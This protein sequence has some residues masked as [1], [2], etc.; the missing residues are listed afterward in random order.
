MNDLTYA[1][2]QLLRAPGV[3]AASILTLA[4]GIGATTALFTI[5]NSILIRPLPYP[6]PDRLARV[7]SSYPDTRNDHGTVSMPDL[8][9][10]ARRSRTFDHMGLFSSL[11]SRLVLQ[12]EGSATELRTVHVSAGFFPVLGV[13]PALGRVLTAA[14][15]SEDPF[16][17]VVSHGFWQ[18]VLG[19]DST[20]IGRT[21]R[22]S[23]RPFTVVGVMP[24]GFGFPDAD[25]DVWALLAI[26]RPQEIPMQL[27]GV[28]FLNAIGRLAGGVTVEQAETDLSAVARGLAEE[29]PESNARLTAAHVVPLREEIVGPVRAGLLVLLGA[30]GLVLLIAC[31]N[32][33]NLRL[34][35]GTARGREFAIRTAT[36]AGRGRL[37]RLLLAESLVIAIVGGAAGWLTAVWAVEALAAR[38]AGVLPRLA[39]VGPNLT[40]LGFAVGVSLL[41]VLLSGMAPALI[42]TQGD[43]AARLKE[44]AGGGGRRSR[45]WGLVA[46]EVAVAFVLLVGAGLLVR[47]VWAL[48]RVDLGFEA[49]S[50]LAVTLT[51]PSAR[52]PERA[53]FLAMHA[54]LLQ[55]FAALPGVEAV[56]SIRFAPL[57]GTGEQ[58]PWSVPNQPNAENPTTADMLQVTPDLFHA[59]GVPLIAG[60][61]FTEDDGAD[62]SV[63]VINQ[64]LARVAF[65]NASGLGK[66]LLLGNTTL[67]VIGVVGDIRQRGLDEPASPAIY[68]TN[69]QV[70]RRAMAFILR[71]G[72]GSDP[73]ALSGPV[74]RAV[75]ALDPGLAI[76]D[77]SSMKALVGGSIERPRFFALLLASFATLA[78]VLA[79][80]GIYGVLAF[81]VRQRGREIGIRA[82]LGESRS[83]TL[84]LVVRQGMTPVAVGL[85]VGLLG[86]AWL[87]RFLQRLLFELEPLDPITYLAVLG[88]LG[89]VALAAC[90]IPGRRATRVDPMEALR[91]E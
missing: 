73:L 48:Q 16:R 62:A 63:I 68:V 35:R 32:V 71:A 70:P 31:A 14:D 49:S 75:R 40:V 77:L 79:A 15:E 44:G 39:E 64:A 4:L 56:G 80:I 25:L 22:L 85:A 51:L 87:T 5:V 11:P 88:L 42:L 69:R 18:R 9:E 27:R 59:L 86:A 1:V 89:T 90:L 19:S 23:D 61:V 53:D 84:G 29:Y 43:P 34:A 74:Q 66:T 7:Y 20:A 13:Q 17:V 26:I 28:R 65:G 36:G 37:V 47:S 2:R 60:R 54:R 8:E 91:R 52:Y 50:A 78:L 38:S 33:A 82:A 57:L 72:P 21:L 10:W 3:S 45:T 41:T 76:S 6:E 24:A 67:T 81:S 30:V 58:V 83:R 12:A 46:A 55:R